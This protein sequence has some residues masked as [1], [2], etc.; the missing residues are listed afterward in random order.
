M[1]QEIPVTLPEV[2][3]PWDQG[4]IHDEMPKAHEK[5]YCAIE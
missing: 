5:L 2:P 1:M 3:K 4:F